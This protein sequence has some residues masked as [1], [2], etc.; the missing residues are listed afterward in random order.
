MAEFSRLRIHSSS[1]K[2]ATLHTVSAGTV[3][4]RPVLINVTQDVA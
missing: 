3:T 4:C 2:E 1:L